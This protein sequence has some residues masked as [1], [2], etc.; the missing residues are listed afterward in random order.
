M[1]TQY[2]VLSYRI[3]LDF[4]DRKL[5]IKLMRIGTKTEILTIK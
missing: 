5:A 4:H 3:D 1:Q 2:I